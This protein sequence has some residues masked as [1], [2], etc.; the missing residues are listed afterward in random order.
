MALNA[1]IT[2][3]TSLLQAPSSPTPL[4]SSGTLTTYINTARN[5]VAADAECIRRPAQL[6]LGA[7]VQAYQ[8]STVSY[9]SDTSV[10]QPISVRAAQRIASSISIVAIDMRPWEWFQ[11]YYL[12]GAAGTPVRA[13]QRGQGTDGSLWFNPIPNASFTISLD[14]VAL[15]IALTSDTTAEAIPALWTDA[16]PFYAAWLAMQQLQRQADA[17]MMLARYQELVRRGRQLATPSELPDR[18]PGGLGTQMAAAK[19]PLSVPPPATGR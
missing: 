4:I 2:A 9:L 7:G 18:L 12:G 11:Q 14:T 13:A 19:V 8:F 5:Q 3:V 15:P 17:N 1:Y 6:T 10:A 16:V